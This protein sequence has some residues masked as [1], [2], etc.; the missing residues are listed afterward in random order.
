MYRAG[1]RV[2]HSVTY[3]LHRDANDCGHAAA[4][5]KI[6]AVDTQCRLSG[7]AV[8]FSLK[9]EDELHLLSDHVNLAAY[10]LSHRI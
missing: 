3:V 7:Y 4:V 1:P 2:L 10:D 8:L 6:L 5:T 9:K